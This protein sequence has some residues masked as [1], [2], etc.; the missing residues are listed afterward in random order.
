[1]CT[2]DGFRI[3]GSLSYA[4]NLDLSSIAGNLNSSTQF[5]FGQ[6]VLHEDSP[7][8]ISKTVGTEVSLELILIR[9][10]SS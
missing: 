10:N 9:I 5:A 6:G 4:I 2:K 7:L 1:M 8:K 3:M